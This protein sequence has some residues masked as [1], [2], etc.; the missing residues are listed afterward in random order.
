MPK[1]CK[2]LVVRFSRWDNYERELNAWINQGYEVK[3]IIPLDSLESRKIDYDHYHYYMEDQG[4]AFYLERETN[5]M[6]P[7]YIVSSDGDQF[8]SRPWTEPKPEPK[9]ER[10]L[11]NDDLPF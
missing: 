9:A 4:F 3:H 7:T 11:S 10:C 6:P 2:F 8:A 1:E 5:K